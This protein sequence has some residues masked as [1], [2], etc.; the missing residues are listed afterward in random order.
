MNG[1]MTVRT[2]ILNII[3]HNDDIVTESNAFGKTIYQN[4]HIC[5]K[6]CL[7]L[8][9]FSI[10]SENQSI[11]QSTIDLETGSEAGWPL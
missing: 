9:I 11:P 8:N 2:R 6:M 7:F 10:F 3:F 5:Y 1:R 4:R